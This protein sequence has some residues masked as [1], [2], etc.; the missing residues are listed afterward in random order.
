MGDSIFR[1]TDFALNKDDDS[2]VCFPGASIEH[3]TERLQRIMGR[4][5]GRTILG[6]IGTINAEKRNNGYSAEIQESTKE[7]EVNESWTHYLITT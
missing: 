2:A 5:N 7:D 3:V 4:G 6:D 1:K